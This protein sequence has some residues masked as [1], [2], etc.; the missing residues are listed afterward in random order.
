MT[1]R[2]LMPGLAA[3]A[4]ACAG[5]GHMDLRPI[6]DRPSPPATPTLRGTAAAERAIAD[7]EQVEIIRDIVRGF[8][9]PTRG[10]ARWIDPQPLA[11]QR[12]R[13]ADSAAVPDVDLMT[14]I[15][16]AVGLRRVCTLDSD[17][18]C[19]GRTG[20]VLRFSAAYARADSAVVFARI[21]PVAAGAAAAAGPGFEM[22]F[23]MTRRDSGWR[24]ASKG[25][26][27][28]PSP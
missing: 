17:T 5:R 9:R 11:H 25:T 6:P 16:R 1:V 8:F 22:E 15:V 28:G 24:I 19:R 26:V 21:T 2:S 13:G 27:A 12:A 18:E 7:D 23:L 14:E 20:H 4:L 3:V 10:Q